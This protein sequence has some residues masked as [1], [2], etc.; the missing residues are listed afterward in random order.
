MR[1]AALLVLLACLPVAADGPEE[2]QKLV[3][4]IKELGGKV[5]FDEKRPGKPVVKVD[6]RDTKVTDD[7]LAQLKSLTELQFLSLDDTPVTDAG[8][9]HVK[10]M[11]RLRWLT[12]SGT[13]V[14][15]AGLPQLKG[16]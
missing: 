2:Q 4:A 9:M 16:L 8:L 1:L 5:K 13:K 14:T 6:L 15:D 12:L 11:K 10:G 7:F 3:A